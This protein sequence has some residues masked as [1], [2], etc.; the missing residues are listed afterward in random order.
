MF[1]CFNYDGLTREETQKRWK[2]SPIKLCEDQSGC[3]SDLISYQTTDY[4]RMTELV[5]NTSLHLD[6]N[7]SFSGIYILSGQGTLCTDG[8]IQRFQ[9]C[10]QF[11]LPAQIKEIC[12]RREG[13]EPCRILRY[14]GPKPTLK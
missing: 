12:L 13:E 14:F 9:K 1:D 2:I 4:F 7:A 10:D 6:A 5:I 11:F 3:E 8:S